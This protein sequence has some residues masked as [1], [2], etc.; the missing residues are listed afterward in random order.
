MVII[1]GIIESKVHVDSA[2][3][4]ALEKQLAAER[5]QLLLEKEQL[6][7]EK[8]NIETQFDKMG[9]DVQPA[10]EQ[11]AID[12]TADHEINAMEMG[13]YDSEEINFTISAE[14]EALL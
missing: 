7:E 8:Q 9:N 13:V 14:E 11:A 2:D 12:Q 10:L 4:V 3:D 5:Q 6:S 1:Q